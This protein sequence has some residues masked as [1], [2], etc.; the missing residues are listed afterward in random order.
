MAKGGLMNSPTRRIRS[1]DRT[2][3]GS[4]AIEFGFWLPVVIVMLSGI[5]DFGWYMSRSEI[6]MR[7]ARDGAR[8][9]A[10]VQN[11]ADAIAEANSQANDSLDALSYAGC[12]VATTT[13]IDTNN[14]EWLET[15]VSCPFDP[16]IGIAPGLPGNI[17][18]NFMMY[19]ELQ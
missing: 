2:R 12:T 13:D 16:L 6:V 8:Q 14:L 10:A 18:Y 1:R 17:G 7:A 4:A 5:I 3:R 11:T 9:G 19:L 15:S